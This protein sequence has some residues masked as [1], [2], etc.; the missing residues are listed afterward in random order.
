MNRLARRVSAVLSVLFATA[1]IWATPAPAFASELHR[2]DIPEQMAPEA[3]D[4]F[5]SQANVQILVAGEKVKDK[6]LAA[7][8]GEY[9]IQEGLS[10]LLADSGLAVRY[11][12]ERS[13]ALVATS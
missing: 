10:R 2:F 7:L 3:I 8:S 9:T 12:G 5:A 13:I 4:A 1:L 6:P 11:V